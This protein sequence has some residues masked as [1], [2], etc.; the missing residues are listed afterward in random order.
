MPHCVANHGDCHRA[1]RAPGKASR[2][3]PPAQRLVT[4]GA[5]DEEEVN[6]HHQRHEHYG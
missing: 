5:L 2:Q 1:H 3:H 4:R 6:Q